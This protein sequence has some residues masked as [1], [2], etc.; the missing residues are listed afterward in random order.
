MNGKPL[1]NHRTTGLRTTNW[2]ETESWTVVS[3]FWVWAFLATTSN[4]ELV[5]GC[6]EGGCPFTLNSEVQLPHA[7]K[8]TASFWLTQVGFS[9]HAKVNSFLQRVQQQP[10][11]GGL[12]WW[13]GLGRFFIYPP[14]PE[15]P[16]IQSTTE[17]PEMGGSDA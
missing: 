16:I 5:V 17:T 14:Q 8:G 15:L 13:C 10:R 7:I 2:R 12:D 6:L 1:L 11:I 4:H 3:I 9:I